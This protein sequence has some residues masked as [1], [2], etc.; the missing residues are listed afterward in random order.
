MDF[1]PH[2]I[3]ANPLVAGLAGAFVGLRFAPG[4]SWLERITNVAAGAIC[5]GFVAPAVG[6]ML[7]LQSPA[8]LGFLAFVV[9]MFGMSLAS[10][11]M[12]GLRDIR[13]SEIITSWVSRK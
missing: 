8:M 7:R 2:K 6:E 5:S 13:M 12:Q 4:A 1:E 10:A 11:V 3:A 9:G